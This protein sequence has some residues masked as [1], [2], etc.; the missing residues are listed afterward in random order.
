MDSQ[1]FP[2]KSNDN[3]MSEREWAEYEQFMLREAIRASK[4]NS[5][6]DNDDFDDEMEGVVYTGLEHDSPPPLVRVKSD[7]H[8]SQLYPPV[9][10]TLPQIQLPPLQSTIR[11]S[12]QPPQVTI[13]P[14]IQL[15]PFRPTQPVM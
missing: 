2:V 3:T 13:P 6:D 9:K 7:R 5:S 1:G 4:Q 14:R 12:R 15:P 8:E 11:P 10:P